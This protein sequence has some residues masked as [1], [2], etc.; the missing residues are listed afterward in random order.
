MSRLIQAV[1]KKT[2]YRMWLCTRISSLLYGL[3]TWLKCQKT[4]QV[5]QFALEK[6]FLVGGC[7]F[8]VSDVISRG[9]FGHLHLAAN[10]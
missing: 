8:F 7:R 9:L 3:R 6:N 10:R 1:R 2:L 4:R 5:L